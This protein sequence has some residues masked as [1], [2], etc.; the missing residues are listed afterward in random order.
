MRH[1][2]TD[3]TRTVRRTFT[4]SDAGSAGAWN[5]PASIIHA[6]RAPWP[7]N[8]GDVT[9]LQWWR[10]MPA[11]HLGDAQH[12][13][14]LST[15]EKID[16]L[17]KPAWRAAL[18]GDAGARILI[19]YQTLPITTITF[20]IDLTMSALMACALGGNAA[21]ALVLSHVL[22]LTP[23]DH[24]FGQELSASWLALNLQRALNRKAGIARSAN[25]G[26]RHPI[27]HRAAFYA[28]DFS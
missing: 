26:T 20:E 16:L 12:L 13:L 11:D 5:R 2:S 25:T 19:A 23:L 10:T 22:R 21:A 28:G 8:A 6:I 15:L 4:S 18:H 27:D 14:L 1:S 9:P 24:P 7:F 3:E 17:K